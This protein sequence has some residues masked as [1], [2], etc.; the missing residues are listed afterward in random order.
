MPIINRLFKLILLL[1]VIT[2]PMSTQ[3]HPHSWVDMHTTVQG[4]NQQITGLRMSW[5]FDAMTTAYM[6]DGEDMSEQNKQQTLDAVTQEVMENLYH[7][8]YFTY[9]YNDDEP[10]KYKRAIDATTTQEKSRI[11]LHFTLPLS[12]PLNIDSQDL[13][14]LVFEPSYYI[15]MSWKQNSDIALSDQL[16]KICSF[17]LIEPNPSQQQ[18]E[19]AISLPE[20][21]NPDNAL[22]QA[23]SQSI[24][25]NCLHNQIKSFQVKS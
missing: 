7:E 3:A 16:S 8:H 13:R 18:I 6:L 21:A 23:F 4:E 11:T 20:D 25:I 2:A 22:G 9:F 19:H 10:I 12:K 24:S 5:T 1:I 17:D 14:L 15:D